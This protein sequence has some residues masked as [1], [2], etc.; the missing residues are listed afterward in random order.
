MADCIV[1][2]QITIAA[3][4]SVV[5]DALTN[6]EMTRKYFFHCR[7]FSDWKPG[8]AITFKGRMFLFIKIELKGKILQIEPERL[9]KYSLD[10]RDGSYSTITDTLSYES[11]TTTLSITDDVG[12]S[13]GVEKRYKKSMKGWD[14]ILRRLKKMIE[15]S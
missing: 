1:K 2:K 3:E 6:P 7:V 8:S 12:Q 10:G 11:G 5:W 4:P 14:R 9:L 13:E 15:G